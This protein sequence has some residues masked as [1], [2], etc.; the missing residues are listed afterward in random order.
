MLPET[1]VFTLMDKGKP[2][3]I[4]AE[5]RYPEIIASIA[6]PSGHPDYPIEIIGATLPMSTTVGDLIEYVA[7][8]VQTMDDI[9]AR[10][11]EERWSGC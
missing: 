4:S 6:W 5:L 2:Y 9:S 8:Y 1:L 11:E 10:E 3:S 7:D